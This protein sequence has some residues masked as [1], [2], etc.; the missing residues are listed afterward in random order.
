[1]S[2]KKSNTK[3]FKPCIAFKLNYCDGGK[4][5][6]LERIG[7]HGICSDKMIKYNVEKP[8]AWCS[9]DDCVCKQYYDKKNF[10]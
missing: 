10:A 1:M 8:R 9:N 7:F 3:I 4:D 5:S 2:I 6:D